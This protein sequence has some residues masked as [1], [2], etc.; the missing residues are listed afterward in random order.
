M[1]GPGVE[2]A[3]PGMAKG[4]RSLLEVRDGYGLTWI[5]IAGMPLGKR[6]R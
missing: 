4:R 3:V 1:G 5:R 2:R 6:P